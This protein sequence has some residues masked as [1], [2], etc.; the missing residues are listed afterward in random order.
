MLVAVVLAMCLAGSAA[1]R[2]ADARAAE[3]AAGGMEVVVPLKDG[4]FY[5]GDVPVRVAA[6]Q[7]V[8]VPVRPFLAA[9]AKVLRPE[10]VARLK[11]ALGDAEAASPAAFHAAGV[12]LAFDPLK[13]ELALSAGIDQRARGAV[14]V[15]PFAEEVASENA[16]RPALVSA[17]L[18]MRL[19]ADYVWQTTAGERGLDTPRVDL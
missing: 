4:S 18:N 8:V 3:A 17:Y 1:V 16:A 12:D 7:S 19:G 13:V 5:V 9:A 14:S 11:S 15:L 10:T 6:D 2:G